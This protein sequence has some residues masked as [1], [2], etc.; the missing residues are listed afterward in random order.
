MDSSKQAIDL[1]R[2]TKFLAAHELLLSDGWEVQQRSQQLRG[3]VV[4]DVNGGDSGRPCRQRRVA[5]QLLLEPVT[6]ADCLHHSER[7]KRVFESLESRPG[8]TVIVRSCRT[9]GFATAVDWRGGL[10]R[11]RIGSKTWTCL[12]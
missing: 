3:V 12:C 6:L 11:R 8:L 5:F 9:L 1:Y 7:R 4:H 2:S 10:D